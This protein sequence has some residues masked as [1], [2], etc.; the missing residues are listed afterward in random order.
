MK[1]AALREGIDSLRWG[2]S[3]AELLAAYPSARPLEGYAGRNPKTGK[4]EMVSG[5]WLIP[6]FLR[7][8]GGFEISAS[9]DSDPLERVIAIHLSPGQGPEL[10]APFSLERLHAARQELGAKLGIGL[11]DGDAEHQHWRVDGCSISIFNEWDDFS[12]TIDGP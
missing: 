7:L 8:D 12:F 10:Q 2:M 4:T 9:T 1:R 3:G 6:V 11:V 5:G